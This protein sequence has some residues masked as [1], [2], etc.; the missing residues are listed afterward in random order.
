[1]IAIIPQLLTGEI[2]RGVYLMKNG[3][4]IITKTHSNSS[5][6]EHQ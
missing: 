1:M 5:P 6:L 4:I 3:N 2:N